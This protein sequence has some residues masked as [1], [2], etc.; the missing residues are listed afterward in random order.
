MDSRSLVEGGRRL[1][2][3]RA[4]SSLAGLTKD[5]GLQASSTPGGDALRSLVLLRVLHLSRIT[6]PLAVLRRTAVASA[7]APRR[8]AQEQPRRPCHGA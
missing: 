1:L 3:G 5:Q 7:P 4:L 6:K 8:S 2:E